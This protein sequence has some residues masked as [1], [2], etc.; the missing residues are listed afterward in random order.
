MSGAR[1]AAAALTILLSACGSPARRV[2]VEPIAFAEM[3]AE[4]AA[5]ASDETPPEAVEPAPPGA[6]VRTIDLPTAL[7]IAGAT[8]PEIEFARQALLESQARLDATSVLWLP[9]LEVAPGYTKHEGRIQD[10][11]GDV[12]QAS[13][14]SAFVG[15]GIAAS[16]PLE[17]AFLAPRVERRNVEARRSALDAAANDAVRAVSLAYLDLLSA[18]SRVVVAE[19]S[20]AHARELADL[21]ESFAR[22][23]QGLESDAARAR[24]ALAAEE[25]ERSAA[26][27]EM[28]VASARLVRRLA[29]DPTIALRAGEDRVAPVTVVPE[30]SP[31]R[32]LIEE[33]LA[34]SPEVREREALVEAAGERENLESIRPFVPEIRLEASGGGF[35]GGTGSDFENFGERGDVAAFL[36]WEFESLGFGNAARLRGSRAELR[37]ERA[38]LSEARL[39]AASEVSVAWQ[40][41]RLKKEQIAL[42]TR[43]VEE[44][45][46]S[47]DLNFRR[48]RGAEGLPIEALDAIRTA[49]AARRAQIDAVVGYNRAQVELRHALGRRE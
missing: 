18:Q 49:A 6:P 40:E 15:G 46:R 45:A 47:L 16:V 10:T 26:E 17:D 48:I 19:E 35:G 4:P 11:Q 34:N 43:G 21:A 27:E 13:R 3:R 8:S 37:R 33:A 39:R 20:V 42:A 12:V 14:N 31:F 36:V 32:D 30:D 41:S 5:D 9:T 23:G 1:A 2:H 22:G 28:A 29:V 24:S 7:A 38:S 44:S 25:R